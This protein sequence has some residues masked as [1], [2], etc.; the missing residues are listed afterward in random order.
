MDYESIAHEAI[1]VGPFT[2]KHNIHAITYPSAYTIA[3]RSRFG[4]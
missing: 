3:V 2:F 4:A 1:D